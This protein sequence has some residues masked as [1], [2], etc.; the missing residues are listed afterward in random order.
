M[1]ALHDGRWLAAAGDRLRPALLAVALIVAAAPPSAGATGGSPLAP[2]HR[3]A[4]AAS[5]SQVPAPAPARIQDHAP[6][7]M[8]RQVQAPM[9]IRI[10]A[11]AQVPSARQD[12]LQP[13]PGD[14]ELPRVLLVPE[15]ETTIVA[16]MVGTVQRLGGHLGAAVRS[17]ADLVRF[18]CAEP[19]ARL[20]MHR[21]EL[22]STEEQLAAKKRLQ[23]LSAAGEVEVS[24]AKSVV[25]KARAQVQL[26]EAQIDLCVIA[27]PFS[28]RITR[29]HV[30]EHQGVNVGQPLLD[31]VSDGPL[32]VRM[33]APSRWLAWLKRGTRFEVVIDETGR[34]YPAQVSA[35][36]A[37]VDPASQSVEIEG[38]VSGRFPELLAGMSGN[39]RFE[40]PR[41]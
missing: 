13:S 19:R 40:P 5:R 38:K 16:Q 36:N 23:A 14:A 32:E 27:A 10:L 30:R 21:A 1:R 9:P 2:G 37:R 6:T 7:S 33:N 4:P 34:S 29:L 3:Q 11:Q 35:V 18:Q 28:G 17:G 8:Q 12:P 39:A 41:P 24:M 15:R 26:G 31:L 25:D 22:H 20:N